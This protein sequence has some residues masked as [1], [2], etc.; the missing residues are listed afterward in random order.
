VPRL[1]VGSVHKPENAPNTD[2]QIA[3]FPVEGSATSHGVSSR[4]MGVSNILILYLWSL[5]PGGRGISPRKKLAIV[6]T[7]AA[8]AIV[9]VAVGLASLK[10]K[11]NPESVNELPEA[12]FSYDAN[13]LT[14]A[15]NA[16]ESFDPDGTISNYTW[17]FGDEA[18]GY[19]VTSE[20][21]YAQEG[22]YKIA[23]NVTDNK[24]D[25]NA[26][27]KQ[28]TLTVVVVESDPI[29]DIVVI[30]NENGNV[31]LSGVGSSDP[32]GG[33]IQ[34]YKWSFGDGSRGSGAV[35]T[36]VYAANGTYSVTLT[37]TDDEGAT[38][39]TS[40]NVKVTISKNPQPEQIGP[41]G[42]YNAIE[43]HQER[44]DQKP[45][46]QNSLNHLVQNLQRWQEKHG[47]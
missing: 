31:V 41:P 47:P 42:L 45:Q 12:Y 34:K 19:N 3:T 36:H 11:A 23:L 16:S 33:A 18:I 5:G 46:L 26:T 21:A 29:A 30:S 1:R 38:N 17:D 43:N 8:V 20:H 14:V 6:A 13:G 25:S 10:P 39:S 32:D 15:V 2:A 28:V 24:G 7:T 37:V 22:T 9:I 27:S 44:V 35:V 4:I 40:V